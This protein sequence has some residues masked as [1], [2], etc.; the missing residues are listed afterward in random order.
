MIAP[1]SPAWPAPPAAVFLN[2]SDAD[3][4]AYQDAPL[5]LTSASAGTPDPI[6]W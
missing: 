1:A 5:E 4:A 6:R 3:F 2:P